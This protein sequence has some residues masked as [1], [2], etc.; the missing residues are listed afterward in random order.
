ME[1]QDIDKVIYKQKQRKTSLIF[2]LIFALLGLSISAVLRGYYG[3]PEGENMAVNL[4]GVLVGFIISIVVF[5][6]VSRR[7][8][9]DELRYGWNLKRQALKIQNHR[10]RWEAL[11]EK[12]DATA[13]IVL[14][15]Y[16]KATLQLQSLDGN[17]FG[18][19]ETKERENK[20]LL[21]CQEKSV[22]PDP[23]QYSVD[24]LEQV[25]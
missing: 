10:H 15:F 1:L 8:Y 17:E 2:C 23:D 12:G 20:F 7:P 6:R 5:S 9:F 24:L 16:Y 3:N 21:L 18:Y 25:K 22:T 13:A 4:T 11:L 19:N 14:A